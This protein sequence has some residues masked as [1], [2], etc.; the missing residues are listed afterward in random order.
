VAIS[1]VE[2]VDHQIVA[3]LLSNFKE[4]VMTPRYQ[5]ALVL[6]EIAKKSSSAKPDSAFLSFTKKFA[7]TCCTRLP[8][9]VIAWTI[10]KSNH[11]EYNALATRFLSGDLPSQFSLGCELIRS[12]PIPK[13]APVFFKGLN[14]FSQSPYVNTKAVSVWKKQKWDSELGSLMS[15]FPYS[16]NHPCF[17]A[18][19]D[20][21]PVLVQIV[22]SQDQFYEQVV[23]YCDIV[24]SYP[25]NLQLFS[26]VLKCLNVLVRVPGA[27]SKRLAMEYAIRF[28]MGLSECDSYWAARMAVE[29]GEFC[30]SFMEPR[31]LYEFVMMQFVRHCPRF[32][33]VFPVVVKYFRKW[34]DAEWMDDVVSLGVEVARKNHKEALEAMKEG[35]LERAFQCALVEEE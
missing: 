34:R 29:V 23:G 24:F 20:L 12:F 8:E 2:S 6:Y 10:L 33:I 30:E 4:K 21:L 1:Q 18:L 28:F 9:F 25:R 3:T 31:E 14:R 19:L 13:C 16:E 27:E 5:T 22:H 11:A 26:A 17:P 7:K 35:D 15:C 32:A